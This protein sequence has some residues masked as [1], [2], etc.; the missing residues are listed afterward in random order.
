MFA[1]ATLR[2]ILLISAVLG[3]SASA[4]TVSATSDAGTP[5]FDWETKNLTPEYLARLEE[6]DLIRQHASLF[7]M[8]DSGVERYLPPSGFCKSFPGNDLW[9][10]SDAWKAFG[11]A[12][13]DGALIETIPIGAVCYQGLGAYDKEECDALLE[14]FALPRTQYAPGML[15]RAKSFV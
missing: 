11:L 9:P 5:L 8:D 13:G 2:H 1:S 15:P 7:K 12:L 4:E 6:K 14:V 3:T 10:S